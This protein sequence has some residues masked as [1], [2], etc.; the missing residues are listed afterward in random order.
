MPRR[1]RGGNRNDNTPGGA[2]AGG[3]RPGGNQQP[4]Q[5]APPQI[6]PVGA[7]NRGAFGGSLGG[8]AT[9]AGIGF[10][11]S[12]MFGGNDTALGSALDNVSEGVGTGIG[13]LGQG[14]G[15]AIGA[16]GAGAGGAVNALGAGA[17]GA[18]NDIGG[19]LGDFMSYLPLVL[20]VGGV[21]V[22]INM[23]SKK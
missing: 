22:L 3:G 23:T 21:I 8:I 17:G 12:Q 19:G 16:L 14:T 5:T 9:G 15:G 20:A 1:G 13:A 18:I 7:D 4:P 2:G 6:A 11:G 10:I